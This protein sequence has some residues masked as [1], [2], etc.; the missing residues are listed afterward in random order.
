MVLALCIIL[1][2]M[3]IQTLAAVIQNTDKAI[4]SEAMQNPFSD[5]KETDWF[6]EPVMY[7]LQ[8]G[9]FEGISDTI[10]SP[11]GFMT[12]AMYVTVMGRIAEIN[13]DDYKGSTEFSDVPVDSWYAP[14]V[15]WAKE[16]G[17]TT[18]IGSGKFN[19]DGLITREQMATLIVRFFDAYKIPY[20]EANVTST[21]SDIDSVSD[22]AKE[23]VLKLW[24]CGIFEGSGSGKFN[25]KQNATRAEA[26][27]L[28]MTID[29]VVEKWFIETGRKPAPE[30]ET[31]EE[32][33]KP[34]ENPQDKPQDKPINPVDHSDDDS[35]KDVLTYTVTFMDGDKQI[36]RFTVKKG[37]PLSKTPDNS[38]TE[39]G[40]A[41]V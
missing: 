4:E 32:P 12:R 31:K 37:Q 10:F 6:Y 41:H 34:N 8:N 30:E 26:A 28:S 23:A 11:Q 27:I 17:I 14:F 25:P 5:V 7:A 16:E 36:E 21:P 18:G 35:G 33:Q 19:P 2:A 22:Y 13:L 40:R 38:K 15:K 3:P 1:S 39:I 24:R 9:L 29:E 20:P